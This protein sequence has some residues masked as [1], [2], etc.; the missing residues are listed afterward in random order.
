MKYLALILLSLVAC[1]PSVTDRAKLV[2]AEF[3][4]GMYWE[5]DSIR[6]YG[7]YARHICTCA[8]HEQKEV[9]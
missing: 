2:C 5:I 4:D 7:G 3:C 8:N 6:Q 9:F 1:T